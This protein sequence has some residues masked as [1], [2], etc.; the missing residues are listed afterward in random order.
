MNIHSVDFIRYRYFPTVRPDGTEY[1]YCYSTRA[2]GNFGFAVWHER[3]D[4]RMLVTDNPD[5]V[6][7]RKQAKDLAHRRSEQFRKSFPPCTYQQVIVERA[8]FAGSMMREHYKTLRRLGFGTRA[9]S[10]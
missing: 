4:G 9:G 10:S 5:F 2:V 7:S 3:T 6:I 8:E 1:R